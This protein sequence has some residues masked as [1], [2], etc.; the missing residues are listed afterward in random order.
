MTDPVDILLGRDAAKCHALFSGENCV[1][2]LS[3]SKRIP[4]FVGQTEVNLR[5]V[6]ELTEEAARYSS[7]AKIIS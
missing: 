2:F 3:S 6:A 4:S 7:D 5:R 1:S